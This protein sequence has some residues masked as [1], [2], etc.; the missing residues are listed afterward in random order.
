MSPKELII[1]HYL[2]NPETEET[3]LSIATAITSGLNLT[4][5]KEQKL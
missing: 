4:T 5:Y 2:L 3:A 1:R